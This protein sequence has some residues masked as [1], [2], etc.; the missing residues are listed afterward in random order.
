MKRKLL[1]FL[2]IVVTAISLSSCSGTTNKTVNDSQNVVSVEAEK[3]QELQPLGSGERRSGENCYYK[4]FVQ[5]TINQYYPAGKIGSWYYEEWDID[6]VK[7]AKTKFSVKEDGKMDETHEILMRFSTDKSQVFF[8][9]VD[10]ERILYDMD[11]EIAYMDS[12][13]N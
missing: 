6:G 9:H 1:I 8:I 5:S 7:Y 4:D 10:G 11:A 3:K 13:P 2:L 12:Q